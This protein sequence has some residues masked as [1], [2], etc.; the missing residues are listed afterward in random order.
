MPRSGD[1][2]DR[3]RQALNVVLA[4]TQLTMPLFARLTGIGVPIEARPALDPT[5]APEV[6]SGY[7]FGIWF[8]M[9]A[10][11]LAYAA[12]QALPRQAADPLYRRIGWLTAGLFL[13]GTLWM[14]LAQITSDGWH[15]VI[16]IFAMWGLAL[17]AFLRVPSGPAPPSVTRVVRPM[18]GTL[19]RLADAGGV[20][21][22]HDGR[23]RAGALGTFGLPVTAYAMLTLVPAGLTALV[24]IRRSGGSVWYAFPVAWGLVAIIVADLGPSANPVVAAVAGIL[25]T[26]VG[27]AV[28]LVRRGHVQSPDKHR[29]CRPCTSERCVSASSATSHCAAMPENPSTTPR[30]G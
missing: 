2:N 10:L 24:L 21:Q 11:A 17:T 4:L 15:L 9:Y 5:A 19:C 29:E 14:L 23:P 26:A 8:V 20:P 28:W 18:L 7:A 12:H 3:W 22:P 6:P 25:L 16:V 13:T 27:I 1:G 30:S